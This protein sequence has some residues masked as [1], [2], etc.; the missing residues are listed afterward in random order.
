MEASSRSLYTTGTY[1]ISNSGVIL[2][3]NV[4]SEKMIPVCLQ[5]SR[6]SE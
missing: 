4:I 3:Q 5:S 6:L 1:F 2:L